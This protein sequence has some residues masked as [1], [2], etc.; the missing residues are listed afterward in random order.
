MTG[1]LFRK[2]IGGYFWH[3]E[4]ACSETR[5]ATTCMYVHFEPI[6][7][8]LQVKRIIYNNFAHNVNDKVKT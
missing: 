5:T 8:A 2:C 4:R 7:M 1:A 3:C 6:I